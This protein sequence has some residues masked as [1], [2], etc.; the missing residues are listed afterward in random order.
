MEPDRVPLPAL[1]RE[2]ARSAVCPT[3]T[4]PKSMSAGSSFP[5][6]GS[7]TLSRAQSEEPM[8]ARIITASRNARPRKAPAD[9]FMC[10]SRAGIAPQQTMDDRIDVPELIG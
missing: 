6:G 8:I 3:V 10:N 7:T 1:C 9:D 5:M 4:R 2:K